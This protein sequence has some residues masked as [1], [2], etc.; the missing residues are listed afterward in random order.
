MIMSSP[1]PSDLHGLRVLV[2]EDTL[3]VAEF[4]VDGLQD[5]G[6]DVVGPAPRVA[7]GLALATAEPLDGALL[8]VNL[9]GEFCFPIA[10]A[11]AARGVPFALLTGYNDVSLPPE[12]RRVPRL[13][14]PFEL[15][16][17]A[18]LVE[19]QFAKVS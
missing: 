17:L 3:F 18:K 4:I 10:E 1:E 11:L 16:E 5:L 9:A 8:D 12:F 7:Q 13:T 15:K 6:C 2:V 14:K 19:S